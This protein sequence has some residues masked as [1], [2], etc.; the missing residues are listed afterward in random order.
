MKVESQ[1]KD[2]HISYPPLMHRTPLLIPIVTRQSLHTHLPL[3]LPKVIHWKPALNQDLSAADDDSSSLG[4][5]DTLA[6]YPRSTVRAGGASENALG[7]QQLSLL[8][9]NA[10][11]AGFVYIEAELTCFRLGL[12][13]RL[14]LSPKTRRCCSAS[15]VL[16]RD[17]SE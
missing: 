12:R 8:H 13:R 1:I 15:I 5:G 17:F 16:L 3:L 7:W 6:L 10:S 4:S 2:L 14:L 11:N 9:L